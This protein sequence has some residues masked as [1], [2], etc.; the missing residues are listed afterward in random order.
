MN[1][2]PNVVKKIGYILGQAFAITL[3]LCAMAIIIGLTI[4]FLCKIF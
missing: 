2:R 4:A 1:I 3:V